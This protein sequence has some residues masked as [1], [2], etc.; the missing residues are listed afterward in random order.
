[1]RCLGCLLL[2]A[3]AAM[4]IWLFSLTLPKSIESFLTTAFLCFCAFGCFVLGS[5]FIILYTV[6]YL[7]LRFGGVISEG[8][9]D[10]LVQSESDDRD[11]W[12]VYSVDY[13]FMVSGEVVHGQTYPSKKNWFTLEGGQAVSVLYMADNPNR[14]RLVHYRSRDT[15]STTVL[16]PVFLFGMV[17]LIVSIVFV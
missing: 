2:V 12:E 5:V 8:V 16:W 11:T 9:I 3:V 1:M 15:I 13:S 4:V 17:V 10:R 7:I 6:P 14:N